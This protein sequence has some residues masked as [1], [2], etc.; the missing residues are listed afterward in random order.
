MPLFERRL[1][2]ATTQQPTSDSRRIALKVMPTSTRSPSLLNNVGYTF[3]TG[4]AR[5][6]KSSLALRLAH[7]SGRPVTFVATGEALDDEMTDRIARH[8]VE[9][10]AHWHTVEAPRGLIGAVQKTASDSFVIVDCLSLWVS[11]LLLDGVADIETQAIDL[12]RVLTD[13]RSPSVVVTNEVGLGIVPDNALAR[14]YRDVLG[15]VNA[16][17]ATGAADA[18]FVVAGRV[19]RLDM[20]PV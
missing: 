16:I 7:S 14:S 4:G 18:F 8:Q 2:S 17:L 10:P 9:R 12:H 1:I 13:R 15:R 19:I 11:N 5:S 3:V 20:P 6:G